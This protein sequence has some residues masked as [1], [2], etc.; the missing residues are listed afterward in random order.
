MELTRENRQF[1]RLNFSCKVMVTPV[2]DGKPLPATLVDISIGGVGVYA[3]FSL[4]RDQVIQI[5]LHL[6]DESQFDIVESI[7]GRVVYA[8]AYWEGT[9]VGVKLLKTIQEADHPVL[10]KHMQGLTPSE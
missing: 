3:D 1:P 2:P 4:N 6:K 8:R 5:D 7:Q 10:A 9:R